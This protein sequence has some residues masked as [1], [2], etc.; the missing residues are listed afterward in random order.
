LEDGTDL[1]VAQK[2][3]YPW[4]GDVEITVTPAKPTDF[5]FYLRIPAWS[6]NPEVKVNGTSA[7][8]A[9]PGEYLALRRHWAPGDIVNVKFNMTPQ[10]IEANNRVV[11]D[12]GRVAVQRGPLVYCLEQLDQPNGVPLYN[13]SL[14]LRAKSSSQFQEEFKQDLLGGVVVL[15]HVGAVNEQTA[16]KLYH[17]YAPS[18]RPAKQVELAFIPYYA[19]AN[20][21]ATPMQVWTPYLR[22]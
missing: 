8:G 11:D 3:N 12:Y 19:W 17:A 10:V 22:T 5:T 20:R 21:T 15:R 6:G 7:A 13:V 18:S 4:R 2:T 1:K 9:T 16:N 14:D